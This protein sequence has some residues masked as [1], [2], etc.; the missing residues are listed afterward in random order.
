MVK[1]MKAGTQILS[2]PM[3]AEGDQAHPDVEIG[4][5]TSDARDDAVFCRYW[6]KYSPG[7]LRTKANSELTPREC[8]VIADTV[9]QKWVDRW[10]EEIKHLGHYR[11]KAR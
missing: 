10:I 11:G 5:V 1:R 6:S 4:F 8:L 9:P 7:D 3:H 2:V